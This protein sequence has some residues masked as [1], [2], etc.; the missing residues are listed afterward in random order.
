MFKEVIERK[1]KDPVGRLTRLI[2]FTA[3]EAK[4]LIKHCILLTPDIG[5]AT[6]ITLLNKRYG[7]PH[8]LLASN[9][10]EV[11]SLA[12]VKLGDAMGFRKFHNFV[13]NCEAFFK[14]TN[15]NSLESPETL[16]I[17]VS[18]LPGELRHR[19]NRTVQGIRRSHGRETCLLDFSGFVKEETILVK[20]PIFSREAVQEN[21]THPEK[22][23]K[24]RLIPSRRFS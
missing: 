21:V 7:N 19:W 10:K 11:K 24:K 14:I 13:L 15:R 12:P 20:D 18:K 8:L 22:K 16:C 3:G 2:K 17:L 9:R 23:L 6:A 1:I 5:Y 4:D